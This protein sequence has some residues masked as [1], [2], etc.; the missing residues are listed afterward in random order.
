[1]SF[2][3]ALPIP[4]HRACGIV[5]SISI[6]MLKKTQNTHSHYLSGKGITPY[7]FMT[8]R[9]LLS[10]DIKRQHLLVKALQPGRRG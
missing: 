8:H 4:R 5:E 1:M 10:P 9:A 2:M 6:Y 7:H 3:C